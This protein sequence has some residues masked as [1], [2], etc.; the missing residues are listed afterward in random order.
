MSDSDGLNTIPYTFTIANKGT[1]DMKC[2][3]VGGKYTDGEC[4]KYYV[5]L[6]N[7]IINPNFANVISGWIRNDD[8]YLESVNNNVATINC[9]MF[10]Q[11]LEKI[12]KRS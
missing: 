9:G 11:P 6:N 7:L 8:A 12:Y 4:R 3:S 1:L 5:K 10:Q 2:K